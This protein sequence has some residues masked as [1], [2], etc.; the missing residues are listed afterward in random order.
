VKEPPAEILR[1]LR[2]IPTDRRRGPASDLAG[3]DPSGAPLS[4]VIVGATAPALLLFLS[5]GCVG[6]R[7]LWEGLS[8]FRAELPGPCRLAVVTRSP[9]DED[10]RAVASLARFAAGMA[11]D[12]VPVVMS[13]QAYRDYRVDGPP[14]FA[15]VG[16]A[17]VLG[18]GVAWGVDATLQAA[19]AALLSRE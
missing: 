5:A 14:F 15:M 4:V 11:D 12:P 17:A 8:K 19:R 13:T 9:G 6:C 18:E 16:P 7:D 1:R 10:V 2:P 3:V